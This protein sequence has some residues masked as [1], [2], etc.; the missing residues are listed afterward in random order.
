[1]KIKYLLVISI[2]FILYFSYLYSK[3]H[4]YV[5]ALQASAEPTI[6][7]S[8]L[9][10]VASC[11]QNSYGRGVGT[12]PSIAPCPAGS[13]SRDEGDG[14]CRTPNLDYG[15][16][17]VLSGVGYVPGG[18]G[19][20]PVVTVRANG[21]AGG[22]TADE[23]DDGCFCRKVACPADHPNYVAGFCYQPCNGTDEKI[24]GLC[25]PKCSP[26]WDRSGLGC[27]VPCGDGLFDADNHCWKVGEVVM[28]Y[29]QRTA[30]PNGG[31]IDANLCYPKCQS[32]WKGI[33]PICWAP[34][35]THPRES[36]ISPLKPIQVV[37]KQTFHRDALFEGTSTPPVAC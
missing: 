31:E 32:N 8:Y 15:Q 17:F 33:G 14:N 37:A 10:S 12:I 25:Y 19:V 6:Y 22:C 16:N 9:M 1:M 3:K 7:P 23:T 2:A 29:E 36:V 24:A 11:T 27:K 26:G 30:C 35:T 28:T 18:V 34:V 20:L 5:G 21:C 4:T 13:T